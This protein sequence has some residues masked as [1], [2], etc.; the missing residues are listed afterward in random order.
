[1]SRNP[2]GFRMRATLPDQITPLLPA[3]RA[4]ARRLA[5]TSDEAEDLTQEAALRLLQTLRRQPVLDHPDRYAMTLLYNLVRQRWRQ[6]HPTEELSD[7]MAM[8]L[9]DAPARLACAALEQA[10]DRL[11]PDQARLIRM[12]AAGETSPRALAALTGLPSGT[13][14][15]RLARARKTLRKEMDLRPDAPVSD[16]Y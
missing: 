11:P 10:I 9:P 3:L 2:G 12:V 1:M 8:T 7:D 15:S 4:R 6:R 5:R 16:L 14:M 13:I